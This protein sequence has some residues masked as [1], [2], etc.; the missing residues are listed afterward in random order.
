MNWKSASS[1]VTRREAGWQVRNGERST[2]VFF[3]EPIDIEDEK[4]EYGHRIILIMKT[5]CGDE[6]GGDPL[7]GGIVPPIRPGCFAPVRRG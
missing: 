5:L 3:Y 2:P 6:G 4:A 7:R 1:E